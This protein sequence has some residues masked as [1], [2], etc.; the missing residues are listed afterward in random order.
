MELPILVRG[1][2]KDTV[3]R[4]Y[5]ETLFIIIERIIS[6]LCPFLRWRL[7]VG[8]PQN[9]VPEG[10][11]KLSPQATNSEG[12]GPNIRDFLCSQNELLDNRLEL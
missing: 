5:I 2:Y 4:Y 9:L 11:Y 10:T 7:N 6:D 12:S 8:E 1:H 3:A